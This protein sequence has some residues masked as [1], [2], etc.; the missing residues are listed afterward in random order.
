M[1]QAIVT[2]RRRWILILVA[3]V[4]LAIIVLNILSGFYVDLLWFHEV[5]LGS[6]FWTVFWSK[7][8][9]GLLFGSL[10]FGLLFANLLIVRRLVPPYR[11][12]TPE[13]EVVERY[14]VAI[15]PYAK[16]ILPGL[17]FLIALFVGIG[18]SGQWQSFL[19]WR[20]SGGVAFGKTDPVY[21]RDI[22]FYVF[23]LPF[24][25]FVQGWFFSA[26]V[27]VTV[28]VAAAHY[29]WGGIRLQGTAERVTPQVKAHLSVLLGVIVLVKAW[30]YF[31]G[32]FDLL[33]STR[34]AV[35]GGASYTD[36]HAQ[37]PALFVLMIVAVICALV[38]FVN[39]RFR[40]W[41]APA[42]AVGL[43]VA[44]SVIVGAA[45]PA[46]IQQFSVKPQE[47]QRETPFIE[48]NILFTRAAFALDTIT[49]S[50]VS[51]TSD[52]TEA[53]VQSNEGTV[54][55]IRLWDPDLLKETFDALQRIRQFYEFQDV[56]VD[57]YQ[58]GGE[59]RLVMVSGREVSQNGIET[60][61]R[62][63][64]NTHLVYT[65]GF[66]AVA[67]QVN[68][69]SPDGEPAFLLQDIPP[70][71]T[72]PDL[73]L[74]DLGQRVYF[75]E[76]QDVPYVAVNTGADELDYQSASEQ[77]IAPP[78]Q[79]VDG[80]EGG[81][82]VSGFFRKL[83]FAWR[84]K[85]VN[86]LISGLI[87]NDSRLL[88]FRD[89]AERI[90]KPAPFLQYD[91]DPYA[92]VVD[93]RLVWIQD[94]YTTTNMYPYSQSVDLAGMTGGNLSGFAN[95]I[96]NSVKV[97][98]DAYTGRM[99]Y[100]VVDDTDPIIQVW[101]SAF[102]DLFTPGSEAPPEIRAHFR[103]P[104]DLMT[105]QATQFANY[106]VQNAQVFYG[107]QDFWALPGDPQVPIS[108][109]EKKAGKKP[110]P[111]RPY[112]V[113]MRL[114][115]DTSE[116]FALILPFTPA[117]RN[118]MIAWMAAPSDPE[119]YGHLVTFEFPSGENI[120]GP[121]QV[122]GEVNSDPEFSSQRTL[123]SRGGSQVLFGNFLVIPM[124][125]GFLY[126]LPVFVKGSTEG[127]FPQLKRVVVVHGGQV[128]LGST[129]QEALADSF[130]AAP[131][132]PPPEGGGGTVSEQVKRLLDSAVQHFQAAQAA[133]RAGDLATYQS[134]IDA[135]GRDI[136]E[137]QRLASQETPTPTPTPSSS[138]SPPASPSS[139]PTPSPS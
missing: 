16:W 44:V 130:G 33:F 72:T 17:S 93:G 61:G 62:T 138:G 49:P 129:L 9:L 87:H 2:R 125:D 108:E 104:E 121:L 14:R 119:N 88:I 85:D 113:Q 105:V 106:H 32:K 1:A 60:A 42:I 102:P 131:P 68:T 101:Q 136:E 124:N 115:G 15:E 52:I 46:A 73:Q 24:L 18:A 90:P 36:L 7:V 30:G 66:G 89:L 112:Y 82:Q 56:D 63:W 83:L 34:G 107:K 81:I 120:D 91:G 40:G 111:L 114:P 118:N 37:K 67:S 116:E 99:T 12:F 139:A 77:K 100:Y 26:L 55:N 135:A 74:G 78:Y 11:A 20:N 134:E 58:V 95:Y 97:V 29:L 3:A 48:D 80:Y 53:D 94:A 22:A 96:R 4:I 79:E 75:G 86:L 59:Q 117:K 57:R 6:V 45:I 122:F 19:L 133:L 51:P 123:L 5:R 128:G 28:I 43:L 69:A 31:L 76:R 98:V 47:L 50:A 54:A 27:G 8:L 92:A 110:P 39:I 35:R 38:F 13:Q 84:Y 109:R 103:Y 41:A 126:V 132:P 23:K 65:H 10:F 70:T 25:H 127:A 21:H 137:A 64:Q 71:T